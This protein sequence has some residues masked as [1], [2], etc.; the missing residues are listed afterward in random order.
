MYKRILVALGGGE[1]GRITASGEQ[2]PYETAEIDREIIRL[3]GKEHPNVLLLA[4]ACDTAEKE[5]LYNERMQKIYG[6]L[7]GCPC[8][9]LPKSDLTEAPE[10]VKEA[11]DWADIIY[12]GGGNTVNLLALWRSTGFNEILRHARMAG[13]LLC[14]ISAGGICW[15]S[16]GNTGVEG[17]KE[18]EVN[19]VDGLGFLDVYFSPHAQYDWKRESVNR[20]LRQI[21]K[22]GL[23]LSNCSAIEVVDNQYRI[24]KSTPADGAFR[25]YALRVYW[26]DGVLHEEELEASSEFQPLEKLLR[27][28]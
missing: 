26:K 8:R 2:K 6:G 13:K 23:S 22:V 17:Y 21:P 20:S 11:T 28:E 15:C 14:G 7:Y 5:R 4:H 1:T 19:R 27:M 16:C 24:L 12:E 9:S 10:T 18:R 3:S 25:P